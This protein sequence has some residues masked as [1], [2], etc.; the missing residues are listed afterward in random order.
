MRS[1]VLV[2][3]VGWDDEGEEIVAANANPH[4]LYHV[5]RPADL[6]PQTSGEHLLVFMTVGR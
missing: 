1:L 4:L 5:L 3:W 2:L 6:R